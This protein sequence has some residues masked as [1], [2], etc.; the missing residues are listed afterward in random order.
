MYRDMIRR[1]GRR[2]TLLA[3]LTTLALAPSAHAATTTTV[4]SDTGF[5]TGKG[6]WTAGNC[7]IL[8]LA[9]AQ[10]ASSG[11]NPGGYLKFSYANVL[12]A[13]GLADGWASWS[14]GT[15]AFNGATPDALKLR[16]DRKADFGGVVS[17]NGNV[18]LK[19]E[20]VDVVAGTS[21]TLSDAALT[22]PEAAWHDVSASVPT[23][24][25]VAGRTY[26]LKL[27]AS[28]SG[29][30]NL[31]D[32][33]TISVDNP[34]LEA[35]YAT[36][37]PTVGAPAVTA[38]ATGAHIGYDVDAHGTSVE[39]YVEYGPTTSYGT[40]SGH[41]TFA[42]G[43]GAFATTLSGLAPSTT[44]HA[45]VVTI[46]ADGT[47]RGS[48]F[49]FTT[50]DAPGN[51]GNPAPA[52]PA[53]TTPA[54]TPAKFSAGTSFGITTHGE[55]V[56]WRVEYGTSP[57]FGASVT[58]T[59]TGDATVT[60]TLPHLQPGTTYY[61]RVVLETASHTVTGAT[62]SF[63][64]TAP[65]APAEGTP[66]APVV[67]QTSVTV[68]TTVTPGDLPLEWYVEWEDADGNVHTTPV[69]NQAAG[70]SPV[71]LS[72]TITGL[73]PDKAYRA[74]FVLRTTQ[75]TSTGEWQTFRTDAPDPGPSTAP[76]PVPS[77]PVITVT[78]GGAQL[79]FDLDDGG[80]PVSWSV[81]YG[82]TVAYGT[83][84]AVQTTAGTGVSALTAQLTGLQSSTVYHG[85]IVLVAADG[86]TT[87][88]TFTFT[89][90]AA[91]TGGGTNG[92]GTD[93]V[94]TEIPAGT[95]RGAGTAVVDT[96][97]TPTSP[98]AEIATA[99]P[100]P[101]AVVATGR[102]RLAVALRGRRK[103]KVTITA[104]SRSA[105]TALKG[106]DI[107]LPTALRVRRTAGRVAGTITVDGRTAKVR[108]SR[109]GFTKVKVAGRV[110]LVK[111]GARR[112][113]VRGLPAGARSVS[114]T[115]SRTSAK[116]LSGAA[117]RKAVTSTAILTQTG[118]RHRLSTKTA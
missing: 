103:L 113:M 77:N 59:V 65:T 22:T 31:L 118:V 82:T 110:V 19:T 45:R 55:A 6:Q 89:T 99:A 16:V 98:R 15:F 80:S 97:F 53:A 88:R 72:E 2:G 74:R 78:G 52:A 91:P 63:T 57:S 13:L 62:V 11:G 47:T 68:K 101:K 83:T 29:L 87:Y 1:H 61:A 43:T 95:T 115:L 102:Y 49:T 108:V 117:R 116:K 112:L 92:S 26:R 81:E 69:R 105:A 64:T 84:T 104:P 66:S 70:A 94:D 73:T 58:G 8:C 17:V 106:V 21:R 20:L 76:T 12:N 44:Y 37:A 107:T 90:A 4:P 60:P 5:E 85:R 25:L 75:S 54:I 93:L 114:L 86:T 24:A 28:F 38:T 40:Q 30:V 50:A 23:N 14:S 33:A 27:T 34:R 39:T 36:P 56:D 9:D 96:T 48:D 67:T 111:L 41:Q 79:A 71:L 7:G 109:L 46:T 100:A 51:P 32:G 3:A 35:S 10:H 18:R 42:T